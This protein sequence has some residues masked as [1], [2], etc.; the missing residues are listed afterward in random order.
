MGDSSVQ[1]VEGG[2]S[3]ESDDNDDNEFNGG[4]EENPEF[5]P[6]HFKTKQ[7][8]VTMA[9]TMTLTMMRVRVRSK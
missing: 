5:Y 2:G 8:I 1:Q 7:I 4:D 6:R 9:T 3:D